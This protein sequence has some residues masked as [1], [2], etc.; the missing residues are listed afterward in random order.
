MKI[1]TFFDKKTFTL[2][3]IAFDET[4]KDAIVI[5]PVWD[6]DP[7]TQKTSTESISQVCSYIND[8]NLKVHYSME[9]HAH[10][11]HLSGSQ[12]L[13]DEFPNIKVVIGKGITKVQEAFKKVFRLPAESKGGQD[14]EMA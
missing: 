12:L 1:K 11:D 4:S 13:K 10:A 6:Y 8:N 3:Y 7:I 2:T 5:D 9:T 14:A